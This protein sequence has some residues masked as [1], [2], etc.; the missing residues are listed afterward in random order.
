MRVSCTY[1][2][3]FKALC[4]SGWFSFL[5]LTAAFA[6]AAEP[7][8]EPIDTSA[9]RQLNEVFVTASKSRFNVV[10]PM[11]VQTLS[12]DYLQNLNSLSVADALRYLSGV[13][14]KD[15]GGVGGLKTVNVRSLGAAHTAVFYDG[16]PVG[17][18]Q[19]GQVDLSKFSLDNIEEIQLYNG[20][21]S[22]IFQPARGFF[23]SNTLFLKS[24]TPRFA[25][26]ESFHGTLGLKA[27]SFG[28]LN[29]SLLWEQKISRGLSL[30]VSAEYLSSN[31]EYPYRY[32]NGVYDTT[33]TRRNGD[34]EALR[35]EL[36]LYAALGATGNASLK[37][38]VY[39]S[40]RG[41]PGAVKANVFNHS[42]RETDRNIFVHGMAQKGIGEN[43]ELLL[44]L[45]YSHDYLNYIDPEYNSATP[46]NVHYIQD[47][48]YASLVN[49]YH[50]T[51]WCDLSLAA[52]FSADYM[53]ADVD[54]FAEPARYT[55]LGVLSADLHWDRFTL[56]AGAMACYIDDRVKGYAPGESRTEFLPVL[57]VSYQPF[58]SRTFRLR[59]FYKQSF[60]MPTF[61]E[62][63]YNFAG[64][65]NLK[66]EYAT[67]YDLGLTWLL[68]RG[69]VFSQFS[70]Q[71]DVYYNRIKDKIVIMPTTNLFMWTKKNIGTEIAGLEV[72]TNTVLRPFDLLTFSLGLNYTYQHAV[73]AT[74]G[75]NTYGRQIPYTPRHSGSAT[76]AALWRGWTLNY[77]FVYTGERYSQDGET[78]MQPWY[79]SDVA[80]GWQFRYE[81]INPKINVEVNNLFNQYYDVVPNFPMPGRSFRV[82]LSVSI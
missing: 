53:V 11:P 25:D 48:L 15:Y 30:A 17:N 36:S 41:L 29:P 71:A 59:A 20:Q 80:L 5:P 3:L 68:N 2:H 43:Y 28:L 19:N 78:I 10:S 61:N 67:Q 35:A 63:Y 8:A 76:L 60:R 9:F 79:T 72:N 26:N 73:D 47:E 77:S 39:S 65:S 49:L 58:E 13:Q 54:R 52:D 1:R 57:S 27:G 82:T 14:L 37:A 24:R 69:G 42:Q 6:I 18:T 44:N 7:V 46:I 21:K 66:P 23:A 55:L 74:Q 16:M 38:Y 62:L 34:I 40:E 32:T 31:G 22:S 70:L 51:R 50:L 45:K 64:H 56:Q 75:S 4:L 81:K 12:G 33:L